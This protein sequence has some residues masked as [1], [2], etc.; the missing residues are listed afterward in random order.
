MRQARTQLCQVPQV[1]LVAMEVLLWSH[2]LL[3]QVVQKEMLGLTLQQDK[4]MYIT[5]AT[6]LS[7]HQVL[8]ELLDHKVFKEL[9]DQLDQ[10][11]QQGHK[12]LLD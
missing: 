6:G 1:R 10:Q 4:F 8:V 5:T 12:E 11:V 9:L 2:L 7:L 3:Q